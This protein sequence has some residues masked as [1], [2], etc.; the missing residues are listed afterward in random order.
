LQLYKHTVYPGSVDSARLDLSELGND[1]LAPF[2]PL[3]DSSWSFQG[4]VPD[5]SSPVSVKWT[6][7]EEG[8]ALATCYLN[9][10]PFLSG[11]LVAG[12]NSEPDL[13]IL[14]MFADSIERIQF[15][16]E[17]TRRG[18]A[19][20]VRKLI[21]QAERPLLTSLIW[22]TI[23]PEVLSQVAGIDILMSAAFL[24]R[25]SASGAKTGPQ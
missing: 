7:A 25:L 13:E 12:I 24:N 9:G 14:Q 21:S 18:Q 10:Q 4:P 16:Q 6:G 23:G 2:L 15:V 17:M 20:P 3:F 5:K 8:Q 11:V 22:P 1:L 19:P